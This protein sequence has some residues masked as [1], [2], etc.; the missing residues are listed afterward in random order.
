VHVCAGAVERLGVSQADKIIDPVD[1]AAG[2]PT[3]DDK[4]SAVGM[5][6]AALIK[7]GAPITTEVVSAVTQKAGLPQL[8]APAKEEIEAPVTP[9]KEEAPG[10]A[11]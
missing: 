11:V 3:S 9:K 1:L 2:Q 10:P 4:P 8:V 5:M 7:A 6:I